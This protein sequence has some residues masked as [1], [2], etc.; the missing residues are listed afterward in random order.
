MD[1]S[2]A[3]SLAGFVPR[4]GLIVLRSL[5]KFFGL[6]GARIGFVLAKPIWLQRLRDYLG[7]WTLAGPSRWVAARALADRRWQE[8]ARARL[9]HRS[10]RLA[11]LL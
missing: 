10:A 9:E 8:A 11:S 3:T 4:P 2:A 6:A 7:P 1:P 5:G